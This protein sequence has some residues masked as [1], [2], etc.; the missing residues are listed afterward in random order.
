MNIFMLD[1]DVIKCAEYHVDKHVVKMILEYGQLLSTA[2]HVQGSNREGM[3]KPAYVNHP[4]GLWT[5][6]SQENYQWLYA[7]WCATLDEYT[8]RYGRI[9]AADRLRDVLKPSP[10]GIKR[11]GLIPLLPCMDD[12]YVVFPFPKNID[13][14][15]VNYRSYYVHG[16]RRM[17]SWRRRN[18]PE[19]LEG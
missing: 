15:I 9:H 13:Q 7:L 18:R 5:R 14:S 4:C 1:D 8:F 2:H 6:Q 10:K 11:R 12:E 17:H 3:Y 16:K 19:W